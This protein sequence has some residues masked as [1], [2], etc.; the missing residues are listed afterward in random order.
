MAKK[1]EAPLELPVDGRYPYTHAA[2]LIRMIA[3][4]GKEG[5]KLSRSDASRIRNLFAAVCGIDDNELAAKL[6]DHYLAN[7]EELES[8][9]LREIL[10]FLNEKG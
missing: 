1:K 7:R 10:P 9:V 6:A 4:Y 8:E 2:D 5:T 3:G